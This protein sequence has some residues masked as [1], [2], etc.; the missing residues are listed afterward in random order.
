MSDETTHVNVPAETGPVVEPEPQPVQVPDAVFL[1]ARLRQ[2]LLE[3]AELKK[4]VAE[5]QGELVTLRAKL[6]QE[7]VAKLD[8][9]YQIGA[10]TVLQARTD[11]TYWRLPH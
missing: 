4:L 3:N 6:T 8:R 9:D 2:S 5:L 11:G 1:A 10:G 7:E